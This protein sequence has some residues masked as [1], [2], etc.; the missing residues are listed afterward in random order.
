LTNTNP[1]IAAAVTPALIAHR[2][3]IYREYLELPMNL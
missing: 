1:I 3:F 2:D